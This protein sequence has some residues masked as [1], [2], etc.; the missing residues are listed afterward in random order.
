MTVPAG[1]QHHVTRA[2][3]GDCFDTDY[4]TYHSAVCVIEAHARCSCHEY[5]GRARLASAS[6][7]NYIKILA[8][9][10]TLPYMICKKKCLR[11]SLFQRWNRL[12]QIKHP[13][14][15]GTPPNQTELICLYSPHLISYAYCSAWRRSSPSHSA[16]S[17]LHVMSRQASR[18]VQHVQHVQRRG[19]PQ[20]PCTGCSCEHVSVAKS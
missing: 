2:E 15:A 7:G 4:M 3:V 20:H 19:C 11:A 18:A 14:S 1:G 12:P 6:T 8:Y 16:A 5:D 17:A 9:V 13:C 10:N